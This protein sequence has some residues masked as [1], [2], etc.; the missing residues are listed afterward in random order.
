MARN[1]HDSVVRNLMEIGY[2]SRV[3]RDLSDPTGARK[4]FDAIELA[5]ESC[6]Q[7]I[8]GQIAA[9]TSDWDG[10]SPPTIESV[11]HLLRATPGTRRLNYVFQVGVGK[12]QQTLPSH[13]ATALVRIG[14]EALRNAE[15]H[16]CGSQA[17][18]EIGIVDRVVRL[19]V[20]D[21]GQGIDT[22][23]LPGLIGSSEHLGLR[24]M[25]ALAEE[26][27]GRCVLITGQGAGLRVEVM[28]PLI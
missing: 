27:E 17:I 13:V 1:L 25:R 26:N 18:V 12:A 23:R 5:A 14:R 22:N 9:L 8:R 19:V 20:E 7:A 21:D 16:S 4:H 3:A 24:Q 15:L 28:I 11:I 6:L 10:R 2:A